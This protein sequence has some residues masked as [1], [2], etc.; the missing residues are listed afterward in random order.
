MTCMQPFRYTWLGSEEGCCF[1]GFRCIQG[2]SIVPRTGARLVGLAFG[3]GGTPKPLASKTPSERE[4][5]RES[6]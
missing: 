4:R 3:P 5:E 6:E 2:N 1:G